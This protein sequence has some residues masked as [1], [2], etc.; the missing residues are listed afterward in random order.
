AGLRLRE[1]V[2]EE[3]AHNLLSR[4]DFSNRATFVGESDE[5]PPGGSTSQPA[6]SSQVVNLANTD[7]STAAAGSATGGRVLTPEEQSAVDES[8]C[9]LLGVDGEQACD[10]ESCCMLP[11]K[12]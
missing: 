2:S 6:S 4:G 8:K 5:F 1:V 10:E 12:Q 11:V 3:E 9:T 7:A